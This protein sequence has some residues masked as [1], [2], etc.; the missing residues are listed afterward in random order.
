MPPVNKSQLMRCDLESRGGLEQQL[1]FSQ[2]PSTALVLVTDADNAPDDGG[3]GIRP[4]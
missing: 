1:L 3:K 2:P 4:I